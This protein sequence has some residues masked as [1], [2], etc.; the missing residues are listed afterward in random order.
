MGDNS[1]FNVAKGNGLAGVEVVTTGLSVVMVFL[2]HYG[3][4]DG[5]L[6]SSVVHGNAKQFVSDKAVYLAR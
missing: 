6:S 3:V 1:F 4:V 5:S 2:L